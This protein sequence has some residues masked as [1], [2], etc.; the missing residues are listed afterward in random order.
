MLDCWVDADFA[1]LYS[2]EDPKDPTSV[3]SCTGFVI[4]LGDNPIVWQSKLQT[5]IALS[6]MSTEYIALSTAMCSLIHLR[7]IHHEVMKAFDLPWLKE[8]AISTLYK[9]NQA[10]VILAMIEPLRHM[11]QFHMIAVKYHWFCKQLSKE[12][13]C[14]A[15]INGKLQQANI[16][17]KVLPRV[18]FEAKHKMLIS[19]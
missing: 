14:I 17:T 1:G 19:W 13:V 8:S 9:D 6:T 2:K 7:N 4:A 10:C 5:E 15:K 11:P 12:T 16:L 3:Q 18:Q